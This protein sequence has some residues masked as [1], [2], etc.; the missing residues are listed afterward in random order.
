VVPL[1]ITAAVAAAVVALGLLGAAA[2]GPGHSPSAIDVAAFEAAHVLAPTDLVHRAVVRFVDRTRAYGRA[3]MLTGLAAAAVLGPAWYQ[4][5]SVGT[6][7]G[8]AS[9]LATMGLAG[10]FAGLL[11]SARYWRHRPPPGPV[12]VRLVPRDA[13]A[14][15]SR[16]LARV[17]A[18]LG[19]LGLAV[20]AGST[21]H[22]ATRGHRV[23][24]VALA[25]AA[26][27]V[28]ASTERTQRRIAQRPQAFPSPD[29]LAVDEAIRHA[30]ARALGH[31]AVGLL[32]LIVDWQLVLILRSARPGANLV[33]AMAVT[34]PTFAAGLVLAARAR[35][36]LRPRAAVAR[37]AG[38]AA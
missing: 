13:D 15:R 37:P 33:P 12:S 3:G 25:L 27:V 28:V 32:L 16:V 26:A 21:L 22:P 38:A 9:D 24:V 14:Y 7:R 20:A 10:W 19:A 18:A 36:T 30:T 4:E 35:R 8:P 1:I 31:A 5:I 11:L 34:V 2:A 23:E 6:D 17:A 29:V